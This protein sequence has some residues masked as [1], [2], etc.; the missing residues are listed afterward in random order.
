MAWSVPII[1]FSGIQNLFYFRCVDLVCLQFWDMDEIRWEEMGGIRYHLLFFLSSHFVVLISAQGERVSVF[2]TKIKYF[3]LL[4][5]ESTLYG[6][7]MHFLSA[8]DLNW[9]LRNII[10]WSLMHFF[11]LIRELVFLFYLLIFFPSVDRIWLFCCTFSHVLCLQEF[12]FIS[13]WMIIVCYYRV[14][15]WIVKY[16]YIYIYIYTYNLNILA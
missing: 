7:V 3:R 11:H 15:M 5:G 14:V 6:Y 8:I 1:C 2:W 9:S 16:I 10:F 12:L 13:V 4:V